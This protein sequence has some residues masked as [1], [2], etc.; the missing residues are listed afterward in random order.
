MQK[1]VLLYK[2]LYERYTQPGQKVFDPYLGSGSSRIAAWDMGLDFYG[3]EIDKTY[4]DRQEAR[5]RN[6]TAQLDFFDLMEGQ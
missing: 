2:W 4:F 3:C 5:F 1:P 6:H